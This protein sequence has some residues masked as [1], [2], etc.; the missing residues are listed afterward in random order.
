MV[1]TQL[2][3]LQTLDTVV[4]PFAIGSDALPTLPTNIPDGFNR[5]VEGVTLPLASANRKGE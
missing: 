2:L 5:Q 3:V 4:V 1:G